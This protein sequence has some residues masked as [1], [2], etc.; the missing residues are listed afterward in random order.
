[1]WEYIHPVDSPLL[2]M[3]NI[4]SLEKINENQYIKIIFTGHNSTIR[5]CT[6]AFENEGL[7]TQ[8]KEQD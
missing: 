4:C 6:T 3:C 7:Y 5:Q 1:M 8:A 2:R